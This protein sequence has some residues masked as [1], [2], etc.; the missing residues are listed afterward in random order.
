MPDP[1]QHVY[2]NGLNG[3]NGDYLLPPMSPAEADALARG[4]R[5]DK[6]TVN[7]LKRV[8]GWL[9]KPHLGL[10]DKVDAKDVA[11]AGW[12]AIFPD[13]DCDDVRAALA[14]L[15]ERRE[16]QAGALFKLLS[17]KPKEDGR[18]WL[19][20]HEVAAGSVQPDKVPYYL[21]IVGSPCTIPQSFQYRLD[22]EYAVGRVS[23]DTP[24]EYAAYAESVCSYEEAASPPHDS[25][26]VFFG[27]RPDFEDVTQ[28]SSDLLVEPLAGGL[29][30][31]YGYE[32]DLLLGGDATKL[33]LAEALGKQGDGTGPALLFTASHGLG[34]PS[35]H[36]K[37]ARWQ[38]ALV[39]QDWKGPGLL[40]LSDCFGADD[41][42][43]DAP[44]HGLVAFHFA[45]YG[46]GSP[47]FDDFV[48]S[49]DEPLAI[50]PQEHVS[51][52]PRAL[53]AHPAGGA[54]AVVGHVDRAWPDSFSTAGAGTQIQPFEKAIGGFLDGTPVG[55]AMKDFRE[56]HAVLSTEVSDMLRNVDLNAHY[57]PGVLSSRWREWIDARNYT[58]LGDPAVRLRR[59][60]A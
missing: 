15:L 28:F 40:S 8:A 20:R 54:L 16:G 35:G 52:L 21:L 58:V 25:R 7:F 10:P 30:E 9:T 57:P 1:E 49:G 42:S 33:K 3:E 45:C 31:R 46:A 27:P 4:R 38:G 34:W 12:G 26:A 41:L 60:A 19:T 23:F 59:P 53:L 5:V 2:V 50:A 39:T 29:A 51:A 22:S 44:V 6:G 47:K 18:A 11:Q 14:P 32:T 55:L 36:E 17:R 24:D 56:R 37:Q 48:E 13:G 43:A